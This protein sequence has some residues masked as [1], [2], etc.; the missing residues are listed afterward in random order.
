MTPK[1]WLVIA[2]IIVTLAGM[3]IGPKLA[4]YFS[5]KQF[6]HQELL[7][8]KIETYQQLIQDMSQLCRFYS[9]RFD[10]ALQAGR[11]PEQTTTLKDARIT[12]ER[13]SN[14]GGFII[15]EKAEIALR[16]ILN[17]MTGVHYAGVEDE[18]SVIAGQLVTGLQIVKACARADCNLNA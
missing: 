15:S 17:T 12:L 18:S 10:N 6:H 8:K 4:I 13:H 14:A 5:L 7:K 16:Q 1:D 11:P 2:Q 9:D 3:Y